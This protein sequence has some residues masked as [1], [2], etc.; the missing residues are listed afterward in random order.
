MGSFLRV[1]KPVKVAIKVVSLTPF[2]EELQLIL[3]YDGRYDVIEKK[4]GKDLME[5][6]SSIKKR[7]AD[8]SIVEGESQNKKTKKM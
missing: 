8:N 1:L 5:V 6:D 4:K 2:K 3:M 7:V